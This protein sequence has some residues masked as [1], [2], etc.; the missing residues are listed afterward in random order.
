MMR[1]SAITVSATDHHPPPL[2]LLLWHLG[3]RGGGPR[4]LLE[5]A[6]SLAARD[7]VRLSVALSAQSEHFSETAAL[8]VP[9]LVIDTYRNAAEFAA[10]LARLPAIRRQLGRFIQQQQVQMALCVMTHLWNPLLVGGIK[11][12][13]ARHALVV[14]D[15]LPHPGD[16]QFLR[17]PLLALDFR[18][19]DLLVSLT[20]AVGRRLVDRQG[21]A[22]D[23]LV[24]SALGPFL[25]Q[26]S[27]MVT[28]RRL[29]AGPH[30]LLFFGR[31]LPY[32]GLE[33]LVAAMRLLQL[34][35]FPVTLRLVGQGPLALEKLPSTV[36]FER[37]WVAESEIPALFA[38]ADL[39]VL[40]Y[41]E[42]S[43]SGVL[44][45]AL[46]L[47]VPALVTPVGGLLEQ[48]ENGRSGFV[49]ADPSPAGL[50]QAIKQAL[51]DPI[52]YDAL[53]ARLLEQGGARAW[54]AIADRLVED[55]GR[56]LA[57]PAE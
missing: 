19:A 46:H 21:V 10:G 39:V 31:L 5:L 45:I 20:A 33:N 23:K 29:G 47:A 53:S 16:A 42:A 4:Y 2:P 57:N 37:R 27:G 44:P 36:T 48:V 32:K 3:R 26:G 6:R 1:E 8:G 34:D 43:Q 35:G 41:Q 15:A 52:R 55:L 14:H 49:A 24:A 54:T 56:R 22:P 11:R 13:G 28:A 51:S 12:A 17:A 50:A 38:A 30:R 25:Y 7:D 9:T 40:P 18:Q